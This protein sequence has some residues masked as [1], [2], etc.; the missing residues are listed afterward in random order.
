MSRYQLILGSSSPR[1]VDLLRQIGLT[2][3]IVKPETDEIIQEGESPEDYA[4]RN[5]REKALWVD[6]NVIAPSRSTGSDKT[7]I[8]SADTIV[9]IDG[10]T[11]E[12]PLHHEDARRMLKCLSGRTHTVITG[13][14]LLGP[15]K[16]GIRTS[17]PNTDLETSRHMISFNVHTNV[18]LKHLSDAEIS[19]YIRSGEPLDKAGAYAA[20]GV[21]SYMV[22][23]I[24]GSYANVVGLPVCDVV[25]KLDEHFGFQ[26]WEHSAPSN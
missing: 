24:E 10:K 18:T 20:Q 6:Q 2:F 1:R 12:K 26:L 4:L 7:V 9:V 21:G 17:P 5:S 22:E 23:R 3:Q 19:S 14:T 16:P 8:I 13:V 11:L 15:S 25:K